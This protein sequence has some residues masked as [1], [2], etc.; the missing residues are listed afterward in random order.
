MSLARLLINQGLRRIEKPFL[1]RAAEPAQIRQRFETTARRWFHPPWGTR[2]E[3]SDL[4]G[5]RALW[6]NMSDASGGVIFYLHGGGYVFGSPRSHSAMLGYLAREADARACLPEYRLAPENPFPAALDDALAA[7]R[8]LITQV[9][10]RHVVI[11]GDSAGGGLVLSL[12]AQLLSED[13]ERPAG[14]FAFSP[15]TDLTFSGPS[16]RDNAKV[17]ALLPATRAPELAQMY[18]SGQD[19]KDPRVS[20]LFADMAGAPPVWMCAGTTEILRDDMTRMADR[21]QAAGV[22]VTRELAH[23]LP[24]VWP[25]FHNVMPE[26][27]ATLTRLGAW[28]R[29]QW[30]LSADS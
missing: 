9:P 18:L 17:E 19:P 22:Q 23:D 14:A 6:S 8:A 3:W 13:I 12:L 5:R 25:M 16:F 2:Y 28:I 15:L 26:S 29:Q 11:G 7:Y 20:P 30:A 4:G 24:H 10:A 21:M 27:R 1:A